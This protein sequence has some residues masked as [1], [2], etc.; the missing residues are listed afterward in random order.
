L[1]AVSNDSSPAVGMHLATARIARIARW[2][3]G[4]AV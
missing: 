3:A 1:V 4:N 2:L